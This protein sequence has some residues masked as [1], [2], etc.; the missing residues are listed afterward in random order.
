MTQSVRLAGSLW[1]T[2]EKSQR[3][4]L[5]QA[6]SAGLHFLHWDVSDGVF[7]KPGGFTAE[8]AQELS[9]GLNFSHEAH[10]M[11]NH[12]IKEI[13]K[14]SHFCSRIIV[15]YEIPDLDEAIAALHKTKCELAIAIS[16]TTDLTHYKL[17]V[18]TL[19]MS[20]TPGNAGS[21]FI[22]STYDRIAHLKSE[23]IEEVGVDGGVGEIQLKDL[24]THGA[25]WII[26]GNA[27]FADSNPSTFINL[28]AA[29]FK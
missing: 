18:P 24:K 16:P 5:E 28:C 15:H 7:A 14:W 17:K 22:D 9:H 6:S 1:S 11:V 29:T 8:R 4:I 26:A 13:E 12:P 27:M 23:L 19:L 3:E 2:P 10:L 21:K 20:I 25:S